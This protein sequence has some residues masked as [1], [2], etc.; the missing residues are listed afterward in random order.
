[1]KIIKVQLLAR[2][3]FLGLRPDQAKCFDW[4][5]PVMPRIIVRASPSNPAFCKSSRAFNLELFKIIDIEEILNELL[6][7][8]I[9]YYIITLIVLLSFNLS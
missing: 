2:S 3:E 9:I 5:I 1:V 7:I 6:F 4:S 8:L